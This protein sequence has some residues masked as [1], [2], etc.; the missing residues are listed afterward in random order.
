MTTGRINQVTVRH[1]PDARPGTRLE[2]AEAT[3]QSS[4][5]LL[6]KASRELRRS[7]RK[8]FEGAP[9]GFLSPRSHTLQAPSPGPTDPSEHLR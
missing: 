3:G 4:L 9:D 1:A 6:M 8:D 7:V 2:I 5:R